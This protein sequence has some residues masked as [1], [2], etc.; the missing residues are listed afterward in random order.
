LVKWQDGFKSITHLSGE[1][2]AVG[3]KYRFL[4]SNKGKEFELIE[5]ILVN[6]L[7]KEFVG[8]YEHI[9]MTNTMKNTFQEVRP[10]VTL[11]NAEIEYTILKGFVIKMIAKIFP[12]MFRK[13]TQ[14]WLNQFKT[15]AES[16]G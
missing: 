8:Q 13:Q 5:T 11:W 12:S 1:P 6:D 3:S 9:H 2:E 4:Y 7:P 10:G 16:K 15:F 14:K